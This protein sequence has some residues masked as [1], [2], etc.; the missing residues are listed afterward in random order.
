MEAIVDDKEWEAL[1]VAETL[2][3][4]SDLALKFPSV[5]LT[6]STDLL[7]GAL[8]ALPTLDWIRQSFADDS[9]FAAALEQARAGSGSGSL[10][11]TAAV[12]PSMAGVAGVILGR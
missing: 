6:I 10:L 7:V 12:S 3:M 5:L 9:S 8:Q 2:A 4:F 1:T 11:L